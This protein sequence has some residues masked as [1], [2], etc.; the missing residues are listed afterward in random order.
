MQNTF[1]AI[2]REWH[3]KF[4]T[5]WS[6]RYKKK[7]LA[8][9]ETHVFPWIGYRS[10]AEINSFE[11]LEVLRKVESKVE[12]AHRIRNEMHKVFTYAK[13][14]RLITNDPSTDLEGVLPPIV[15]RHHPSIT[16]PEEVGI[17]LYLIDGYEGYISTKV[18]LKLAPLVFVRP[19]ILRYA[20]WAEINLD[21][22]EWRVPA[23]KMKMPSPHIVP[24]AKQAVILLHE[25]FFVTGKGRYVFPGLRGMDRPISENTINA[26][27]RNLGYNTAEDITGHGFR[28]MASTLLNEQSRW[29]PDVIERQ[30]AHME[31]NSVRAAYNYAEYLP[32][33]R[34][35]MQAWADYLD[36]LKDSAIKKVKRNNI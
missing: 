34:E 11:L 5:T 30:L 24:L 22:A 31:R 32:Q 27:L 15:N 23:K 18:A 19:G 16:A 29:H 28:S 7:V 33:R 3:V 2:A 36:N 20:E 1:E 6:A 9:F 26:A 12:T 13:A 21:E 14:L 17:L 8:R 25:L 35:M 10:I 4:S